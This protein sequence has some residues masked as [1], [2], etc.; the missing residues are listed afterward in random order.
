MAGETLYEAV[1]TWLEATLGLEDEALAAA[2][3]ASRAAGLADIAVSASQ[4]AFLSVM[5]RAAGARR[6]LEIGTLG[7]YSAI[8]LA[9]ALPADGQLM[10]L[11]IDAHTADVARAN[12]DRA[13]LGALS[14]VRVGPAAETLDT[15]IAAGE[16]PFDMVF[17]DADK[18]GYPGYLEKA[19]ALSRPG[20]LIVLDNVVRRGE[21]L[22]EAS[23]NTAVRGVREALARIA[24]DPGLTASALQTVGAKGHDGFALVVVG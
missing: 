17:I 8:W 9:R 22:N 10:T 2:R 7:G 24:A 15:M 18:G 1:D 6:I 23:Q 5:A 19:V 14:Q 13:G 4:G 21:V 20:T 11:E 12:L 16:A 3:A